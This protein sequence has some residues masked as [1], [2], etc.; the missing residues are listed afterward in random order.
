MM[1]DNLTFKSEED[2]MLFLENDKTVL[3]FILKEFAL[4]EISLSS[5]K[6]LSIGLLIH[7]F[8]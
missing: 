5:E 1:A 6:S 7:D 3:L 2:K 4:G 8:S